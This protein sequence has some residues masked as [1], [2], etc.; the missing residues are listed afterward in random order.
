[1]DSN[2]VDPN[3]LGKIYD[4]VFA[5][6][7]PT[8][9]PRTV[10]LKASEEV[11]KFRKDKDYQLT[12]LVLVQAMSIREFETGVLMASVLP[13]AFKTMAS[14][15]SKKLQSEYGCTTYGKKSLAEMTALNFCRVLAVQSHLKGF[16]EK[17]GYG[18]LTV[19]IIATLSKELDR[20]QRHYLTSLQ[21]L[22]MG[23]LPPMNVNIKTT[24]TN[25]AN[26]QAIQ[27]VGEQTNVK[28][29]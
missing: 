25:I 9:S 5:N 21:S 12:D 22:E 28:A 6:I 4:T 23:L 13:D 29:I 2:L 15:L 8:Y 16:L 19:K 27:Q 11:E 10:L 3:K 17:D 7:E 18:D 1:M 20:A 24:T 26:Q 14:E